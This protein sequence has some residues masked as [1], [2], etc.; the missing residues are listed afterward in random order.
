MMQM[1]AIQKVSARWIAGYVP[2]PSNYLRDERDVD[3]I[4][5]YPPPV[6]EQ[7]RQ[8]ETCLHTPRCHN[9]QWCQVVAARARGEIA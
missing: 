9:N 4:E 3:P 6:V 8:Q 7:V 2:T 5:A 1:L